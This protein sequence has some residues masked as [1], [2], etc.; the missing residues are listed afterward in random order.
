MASDLSEPG[1]S[2]P[3]GLQPVVT[4]LKS[5]LNYKSFHLVE[6]LLV[7]VGSTYGRALQLQGT[8]QGVRPVATEAA[9]YTLTANSTSIQNPDGKTPTLHLTNMMFTLGNVNIS[10]N[11]E[12]PQGQQVVVGKASMADR[13]FIL[14]M[15]AKFAS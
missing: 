1:N 7:R 15:N 3:A 12:I 2:L 13:A 11:V 5:V 9:A 10:T 6:T 8:L 4:Q 14:V